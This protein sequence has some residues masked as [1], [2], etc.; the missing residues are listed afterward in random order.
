MPGRA[1]TIIVRGAPYCPRAASQQ[2][3]TL[4]GNGFRL[5]FWRLLATS[6]DT[7]SAV[8]EPEQWVRRGDSAR[9]SCLWFLPNSARPVDLGEVDDQRQLGFCFRSVQIAEI[10][11]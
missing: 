7:L 9:L 5:G 8:I 1:C 11:G 2:D 4:F 10:E 6:S 3:V